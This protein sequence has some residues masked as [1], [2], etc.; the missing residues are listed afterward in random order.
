ASLASLLGN[1]GSRPTA[2]RLLRTGLR[3]R[4]HDVRL[5][6]Q[7]AELKEAAGDQEGA[8]QAWLSSAE[9][10]PHEPGPLIRGAAIAG[11]MG[12]LERSVELLEQAVG[13]APRDASARREL[14]RAYLR[15]G[16]LES[17][18]AAYEAA[19]K[20][21]P[22]DGL[23]VIEVT[24]AALQAGAIERI[25]P[26]IERARQV[27]V[28]PARIHAALGEAHLAR[29]R[30]DEAGQ[31]LGEAI[32]AGDTSPRVLAMTAI[33]ASRSDLGQAKEALVRAS[34]KA[35]KS[36]HDAIWMSRAQLRMLN[37]DAALAALEPWISDPYG[38]REKAE[39]LLRI[40]SA[41][42]LFNAVEARASAPGM[43][44]HGLISAAESLI[45]E[46]TRQGLAAEALRP[47]RS[48]LNATLMP[49]GGDQEAEQAEPEPTG[50]FGEAM[51]IGLL[52]A[53]QGARALEALAH[54][55]RV[56]PDSEWTPLLE[57]L[58]HEF[59]G[60]PPAARAAYRRCAEDPILAPLG[61]FLLGRSYGRAHR[62]ELATSHLNAAVAAWPAEHAW[63]HA[64]GI[65]YA[66]LNELDASLAHLQQAVVGDSSNPAYRLDLAR[67]LRRSGQ[68]GLAEEAFSLVLQSRAD[69]S[70][71]LREAAET[72]LELGKVEKAAD[73]FE[74]ARALDPTDHRNLLGAARAASE[75]GNQKIASE[76]LAAAARISPGSAEV[77]MAEGQIR[78]R[79]GELE[80][81]VQAFEAAL[82]AG[83]EL[84]AVRRAQSK[85]LLERGQAGR[86]VT[87]LEQALE[88]DPEDHALW[89]QLALAREAN[90]EWAAAD[91]AVSESI[92]SFP[93][94][95]EYRLSSGRIARRAGQL[96]RAIDE[97]LRA[98]ELAPN[99]PR[100][101]VETGKVYEDRREYS[102]ALDSYRKAIAL[103]PGALEA[104]YRA[105][106]LLRS[107]KSYKNAGELLKRAAELAPVDQ[108][109][110]HQ[111]AAV[112]ALELVHG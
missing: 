21:L 58:S 29:N 59:A 80:P 14:A 49:R 2:L 90:A 11:R 40:A 10:E 86:A 57:G 68:L 108:D 47:L 72:A 56:N 27:V 45:N 62:P 39:V 48:L 17:G 101:Y 3:I 71:A 65:H 107:L 74:R 18:F 99:D 8:L 63:Q 67:V 44:E 102:R 79:G 32:A 89:H 16:R 69:S 100:I 33:V 76:L 51:A 26:L 54:I 41:H 43:D 38:A 4:P 77:L 82:E 9:V 85:L 15:L 37:W 95:T 12:E 60:S 87:A 106:V 64:L 110:L 46:L 53:G 70:E 34:Q 5:R 112:R 81:A 36:A 94:N 25:D 93:M 50:Q 6:R 78:A 61:N 35:C 73:W 98:G 83:A 111:L 109:V 97:L 88:A 23:L 96:D 31:A 55:A 105:G 1:H 103:D 104:F 24:E 75:R 42:S 66:E 52:R 84:T 22:G 28:E 30:W 13:L 92:Q 91:L 19:M 7:L 20:E